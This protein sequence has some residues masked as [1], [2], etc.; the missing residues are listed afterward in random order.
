[1]EHIKYL[2]QSLSAH[3]PKHTNV[4]K[5]GLLFK[6]FLETYKEV[7][8]NGGLEKA[9]FFDLKILEKVF[10]EAYIA[11]ENQFLVIDAV[12]NFL[13]YHN[14]IKIPYLL[15]KASVFGLKLFLSSCEE[16]V[17]EHS[18]Q[19]VVENCRIIGLDELLLLCYPL[20]LSQAKGK[21]MIADY[22]RSCFKNKDEKVFKTIL[23]LISRF[24]MQN[25]PDIPNLLIAAIKNNFMDSIVEIVKGH[26]ELSILVLK[27]LQPAAHNTYMRKIILD[28][29]FSPSDF[30]S[31][32][33]HQRYGHFRFS[34]KEFG[35]SKCE[36]KA[37]YDRDDF[38]VF[39]KVLTD[40]KMYNEAHSVLKRS[41]FELKSYLATTLSNPS[42]FVYIE[43]ELKSKDDFMPTSFNNTLPSTTGYMTLKELG[44]SEAD[45][46]FVVK[47]NLKEATEELLKA[48]RVG[49]DGEFYTENCTNFCENIMGILQIATGSKVYI[50]DCIELRA[51]FQFNYF[52][53]QFFKSNSIL[54]IGHSFHGDLDVMRRS[55]QISNLEGNR[56]INI[57]TLVEGKNTVG[58]SKLCDQILQKQ[59]CKLEQTSTWQNRPLR[60]AQ[61]HYAALDAAILL[62]LYDVMATDEKIACKLNHHAELSAKMSKEA[63]LD[64]DKKS[65]NEE[66]IE[67]EEDF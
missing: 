59:L 36:E 39:L 63:P 19:K 22:I 56:I 60:R 38:E 43:N 50:F 53:Y 34:I 64:S 6:A 33:N 13:A 7:C 44:Y 37:K 25:E 42:D 57:E 26:Q 8:D 41:P 49:V 2:M 24:K 67:K 61:L 14:R 30:P 29:G 17:T 32:L 23:K 15:V 1:M 62:K 27:H 58:L 65:E 18:Q 5:T 20:N 3:N 10:M 35:F 55:F 12:I 21:Y 66:T 48:Q 31:L 46:I 51:Y 40:M 4:F 16:D 45:V 9:Q 28:N 47:N 54:K 52:I 11:I